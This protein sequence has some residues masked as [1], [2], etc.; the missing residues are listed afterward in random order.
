MLVSGMRN[1]TFVTSSTIIITENLTTCSM[2][3]RA[4]SKPKASFTIT[5]RQNCAKSLT[6]SRMCARYLAWIKMPASRSMVVPSSIWN[7]RSQKKTKNAFQ[8]RRIIKSAATQTK[9]ATMMKMRR[10]ANIILRNGS[11]LYLESLSQDANPIKKSASGRILPT[12]ACAKKK[13]KL[14]KNNA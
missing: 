12:D 1:F 5:K 2:L 14:C 10:S 3:K 13:R 8:Y 4:K 6:F 7:A 9:N 11:A